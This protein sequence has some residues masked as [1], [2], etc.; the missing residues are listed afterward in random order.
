[1]WGDMLVAN[2]ELQWSLRTYFPTYLGTRMVIRQATSMLAVAWPLVAERVVVK[3]PP[4]VGLP[5]D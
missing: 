4:L 3:D 5:P 1:M 2:R